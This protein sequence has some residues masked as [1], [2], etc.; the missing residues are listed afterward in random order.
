MN[1]TQ[2]QLEFTESFREFCDALKVEPKW[3]NEELFCLEPHAASNS[4]R[5]LISFAPG[6]WRVYVQRSSAAKA[7]ARSAVLGLLAS[8]LPTLRNLGRDEVYAIRAAMT[9][10]I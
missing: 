9:G 8:R 6:Y 4:P 1:E 2:A 3:N 10:G 7:Q 5:I